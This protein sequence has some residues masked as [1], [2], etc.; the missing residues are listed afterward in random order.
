MRD[1]QTDVAAC[2]QAMADAAKL[3]DKEWW[4]VLEVKAYRVEDKHYRTLKALSLLKSDEFHVRPKE[5]AKPVS[6]FTS[7]DDCSAPKGSG[8]MCRKNCIHASF[9]Y[10]NFA[11]KPRMVTIGKREVVAGLREGDE[12]PGII[13]ITVLNGSDFYFSARAES[14]AGYSAINNGLAHATPE[15]AI[16][17]SEALITQAK[18]E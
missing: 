1:N 11:P 5:E 10:D 8:G 18:G 13:Y 4:K 15:N 17:M 3:G 7:C 9:L 14:Q 2:M 12:I 16:A 6:E